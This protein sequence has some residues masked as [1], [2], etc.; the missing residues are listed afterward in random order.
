MRTSWFRPWMGLGEKPADGRVIVAVSE[1]LQSAVA[2]RLVLALADKAERS[3]RGSRS[4]DGVAE[5]IV[6]HSCP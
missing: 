3:R 6:E 5:R 1:Q 4:T 2:V